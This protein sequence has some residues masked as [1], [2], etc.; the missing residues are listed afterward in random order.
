MGTQG[1]SRC[2]VEMLVSL[3]GHWMLG[4]WGQNLSLDMS[5]DLIG[6]SVEEVAGT[7]GWSS[8]RHLDRRG[9]CGASMRELWRSTAP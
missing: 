7:W 2:G 9:S 8:R 1:G 4:H 5:S 6:W 3:C